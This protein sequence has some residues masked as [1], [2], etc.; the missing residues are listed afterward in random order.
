MLPKNKE[1]RLQMKKLIYNSLKKPISLE[2]IYKAS[3]NDFLAQNFH[4]TC[5]NVAHTFTLVKTEFGK[6]IGGYT[7]QTWNSKLPTYKEDLSNSSFLLS[8]NTGKKMNLEDPSRA[9]WC[10]SKD[11]P[12]FGRGDLKIVD[13][14]NTKKTNYSTIPGSY[15]SK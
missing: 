1:K 10:Y 15:C 7:P 14:C 13:M 4:A 12:C 2:L 3:K 5:D 8:L 6:V 11:G 9:I